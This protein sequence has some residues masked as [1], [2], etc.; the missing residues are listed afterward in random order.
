MDKEQYLK[1]LITKRTGMN[2]AELKKKAICYF[3]LII[4]VLILLLLKHDT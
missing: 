1:F 3:I 4:K 2:V